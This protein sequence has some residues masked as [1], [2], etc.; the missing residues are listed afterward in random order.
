MADNAQDRHLPATERKIRKAREEG[1][2]AR[3]RD[4]GHLLT[5]AAGVGL[6]LLAAPTLGH[7]LQQLLAAGLSFDHRSATE[8]RA[9]AERLSSQGFAGLALLVPVG[10]LLLAAG[11]A[12]GLA[13]GGWNFTFKP[14]APKLE[15]I[16]PL[17]GLAR[18]FSLQQLGTTL[19]ACVLAVVVG[20]VGTLYLWHH[21]PE[22]AQALGMGLSAAL[23]H[24]LNLLAGGLLLL[25][26]PLVVATA[27][28]VPMQRVLHLRQ[29][30]MSFEEL[31][32]EMKESEGNP[33][34][35]GRLRERMRAASQRSMMAAVPMADLVVMN[36]T[37]FAVALKYDDGRDAA[38]RVVAKGTDLV[39]LRIRDIAEQAGVPVLQAPALAR[40]LWAH[41]E[42]EQE[43]PT[44][45]FAAVAQVLAWVFQLKRAGSQRSAVLAAAPIPAVP[46]ELDP[47]ARE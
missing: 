16:G 30:R 8:A 29:L 25:L 47:G 3:S 23:A 20:V 10:S 36:P 35:K 26:L 15:K 46:A 13:V 4:L 19:K 5:L 39:A 27:L 45:L 37:H 32:Q 22:F 14:L 1:Q 18:L 40:A 9:M 2:V 12:A 28:D 41:T 21:L 33:Q 44:Q 17:S 31:K 42:L 43:V 38:P 7:H 34:V 6:L 24:S 11:V